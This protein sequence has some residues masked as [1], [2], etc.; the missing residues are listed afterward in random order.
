MGKVRKKQHNQPLTDLSQQEFT[1]KNYDKAIEYIEESIKSGQ[2]IFYLEDNEK[3]ILEEKFGKDWY[4]RYGFV[5][6]DLT[7]IVTYPQ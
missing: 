6:G 2:H 3:A 4:K 5:K 7:G 1:V